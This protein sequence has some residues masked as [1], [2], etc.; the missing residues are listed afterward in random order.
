MGENFLH[1]ERGYAQQLYKAADLI[2]F[3]PA[4]DGPDGGDPPAP[5]DSDSCGRA[6]TRD[7]KS[8]KSRREDCILRVR[9]VNSSDAQDG[10]LHATRIEKCCRCN[11]FCPRVDFCLA[12]AKFAVCY[13]LSCHVGPS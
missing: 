12:A 8:R 4:P 13:M 9:A 1:A 2:R 3:P 11:S 10:Q 7:E 5:R 6:R